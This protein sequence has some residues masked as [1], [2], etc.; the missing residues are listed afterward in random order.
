MKA[1]L[2]VLLPFLIALAA[3]PL[4]AQSVEQVIAKARAYLGPEA[5][6]K[7]V[8]TIRFAGVIQVDATT[9]VPV[10]I[11]F[12]KDY[13]QRITVTGPKVIETTALDGYDA[14]QKRSNPLN[15]AQWQVTLLDAVQVKR[16]RANTWENLNFFAGL[17]RKGGT[18]QLQ[19]EVEV[20]GVA[21]VTLAFIHGP[22]IVFQRF[23]DKSTGRLIKTVT[24][25]GAEIRE[26]GEVRVNGIRFPQRVINKTASGQ[27][28][29]IS[30]D[31]VSLNGLMPASEFA[32]PALPVN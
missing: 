20:D 1:R 4:S 19:G 25:N 17:E 3:A 18:V 9:R 24:E 21:C 2:L 26:E 29:T 5:A 13:Q 15:L 11:V 31:Q 6:L 12:Q 30:F 16:L 14:W 8:H 22:D 23:F 28:T 10:E 7:A 32:V 27:V